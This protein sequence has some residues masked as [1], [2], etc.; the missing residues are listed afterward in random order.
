MLEEEQERPHSM[1]SLLTSVSLTGRK[2]RESDLT[3]IARYRLV[4]RLELELTTLT[5]SRKHRNI[6]VNITSQFRTQTASTN[7]GQAS[8]KDQIMQ[9]SNSNNGTMQ[10]GQAGVKYWK[11]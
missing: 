5:T 2:V 9:R 11:Y 10:P 7:I 3:S 6:A 4:G 8:H 1:R